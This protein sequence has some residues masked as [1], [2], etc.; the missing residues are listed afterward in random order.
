GDRFG[1]DLG[2]PEGGRFD[3]GARLIPVDWVPDWVP[4]DL[5][6]VDLI[7]VD[8]VQMHEGQADV[9]DDAAVEARDHGLVVADVYAKQAVAVADGQVLDGLAVEAGHALEQGAN[10]G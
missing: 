6:A 1:D 8:W 9:L 10:V 4:V 7:P 3:L 2:D 5:I